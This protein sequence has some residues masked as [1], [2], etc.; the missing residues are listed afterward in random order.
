[1]MLT[2]SFI[3]NQ[4]R[5]VPSPR[6]S[7][8]INLPDHD[9]SAGGTVP[10]TEQYRQIGNAVPPYGQA[11]ESIISSWVGQKTPVSNYDLLE[12]SQL[13]RKDLKS[14]KNLY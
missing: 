8:R 1:M 14:T 10:F 5:T 13:M 3:P 6:G 7:A 12:I 4:I 2:C 9:F 11:M